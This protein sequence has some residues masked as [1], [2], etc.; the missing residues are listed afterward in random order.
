MRFVLLLHSVFRSSGDIGIAF[1]KLTIKPLI[2]N[3][4][5]DI[6][7]T[8]LGTLVVARSFTLSAAPKMDCFLIPNKIPFTKLISTTK[9]VLFSC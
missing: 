1:E 5:A 7:Y 9:T 8:N 4:L 2:N 3:F 6:L